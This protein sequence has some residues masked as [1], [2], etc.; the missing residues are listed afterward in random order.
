MAAGDNVI[1]D[2]EEDQMDGGANQDEQD[3]LNDSQG[4]SPDG[5]NN[6]D[7]QQQQEEIV[8]DAEQEYAQMD[9]RIC[10]ELSK[11]SL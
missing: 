3:A 9:Y 4:E 6:E 2:G 5:G 11:W 8:M 1:M 7:Q 10:G